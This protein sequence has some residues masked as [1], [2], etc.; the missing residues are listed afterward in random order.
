MSRPCSANIGPLVWLPAYNN[1]VIG[2]P[3]RPP[4]RLLCMLDPSDLAPSGPPTRRQGSPGI[5]VQRSH[6]KVQSTEYN[7]PST[8]CK[9]P[10]Q[11]HVWGDYLA[12]HVFSSRGGGGG[13][14]FKWGYI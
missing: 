14:T 9:A 11:K 6:H 8:E 13:D 3:P 7:L 5:T 2:H 4:Q 10:S 1:T 12:A